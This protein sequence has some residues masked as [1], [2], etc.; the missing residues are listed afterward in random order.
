LIEI[1]ILN[2]GFAYTKTLGS[3]PPVRV[4]S[5]NT[6]FPGFREA[7]LH[8]GDDFGGFKGPLVNQHRGPSKEDITVIGPDLA[9]GQI[10]ELFLK[11]QDGV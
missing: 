5:G 8:G 9:G 2:D 10:H 11:S 1:L 4:K 6:G 7:T 3:Q